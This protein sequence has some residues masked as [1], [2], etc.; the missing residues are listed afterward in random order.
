MAGCTLTGSAGKLSPDPILSVS[1]V[2]YN[3][4]HCLPAFFLPPCSGR[5]T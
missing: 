3:S 4:R 1:V 2:T 5:E